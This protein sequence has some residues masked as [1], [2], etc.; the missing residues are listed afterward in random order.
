[1]SMNLLAPILSAVIS[2]W[3]AHWAGAGYVL[4]IQKGK[5]PTYAIV[6]SVFAIGLLVLAM[7]FMRT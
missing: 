3:T 4:A 6:R 1:M 2:C 5:F 7:H